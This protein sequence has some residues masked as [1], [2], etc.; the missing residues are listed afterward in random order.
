MIIREATR[1]EHEKILVDGYREWPKGRTYE[2]YCEDN[3]KEDAYG[4]RWVLDVGGEIVSSL[5]LLRFSSARSVSIFGIGSVVTPPEYRG[6]GYGSALLTGVL[7]QIK[8]QPSAVLLHSGIGAD[9]YVALGF[10]A[11]PDIFQK[12]PG[13][14]YMIRVLGSEAPWSQVVFPEDLPDYF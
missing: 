5:I 3:K 2:A 13:S 14:L 1:N 8:A 7:S 12:Y 6:K 9:F 11:L 10:T 4:T